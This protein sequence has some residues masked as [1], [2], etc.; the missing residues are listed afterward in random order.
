MHQTK[1]K[2]YDDGNEV[3]DS[4]RDQEFDVEGLLFFLGRY[5]DFPFRAGRFDAT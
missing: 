5:E 2:L 1:W 4:A 3:V